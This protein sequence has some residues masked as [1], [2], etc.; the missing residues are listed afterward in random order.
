MASK[1]TEGVC[2]AGGSAL[3]DWRM[4]GKGAAMKK[5]ADC[6]ESCF[7]HSRHGEE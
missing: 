7:D 5:G 3:L 4:L 2:R 1:L 6:R